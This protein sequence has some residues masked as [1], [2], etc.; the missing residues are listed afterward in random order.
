MLEIAENP[1]IELITNADLLEVKGFIGN[2]TVTIRKNPRYIKEDKC[3]GCSACI[4][5]CPI[6]A[7]NE[8]DSGLGY[9]KAIYKPFSQAVPNIVLIDSA[10]CINCQL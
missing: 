3:N 8:F 2:F 4:Q 5:A 9:R 10:K 6:Y 1:L 7:P